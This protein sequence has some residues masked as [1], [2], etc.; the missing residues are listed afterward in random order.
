MTIF[1][2]SAF[3]SA[4]SGCPIGHNFVYRNEVETTM[5]VASDEARAGAPHGTL[6]L[7][8][9][10][11][12]GRGRQGRTFHSPDAENLYFTLVLRCPT[13]VH[14][15]LPMV[16]PLAVARACAGSGA[17][18]RIKWPNDIWIGTRK[19]CGMLIDAELGGEGA[20][21]LAGIGINVNGDPATVPGLETVATSLSRELGSR[22]NR[23]RLLARVCQEIE[24]GLTAS[25][26]EIA[27]G[28]A[29][30]SLVLGRQ[31]LLEF[32]DGSK[33]EGVAESIAPDG[34][35]TVRYGDG[36]L[37]TVHAAGVSLRPR[38]GG[39]GS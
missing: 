1:D 23:E 32:S 3:R 28:Y 2:I 27:E 5:T 8:E 22:Q 14:R 17:E 10:Q 11:T 31:V 13:E 39:G 37:A 12:A 36:T 25:A 38:A 29:A 24:R 19:V 9:A 30:F 16:L 7:A 33:G 6:V 35:L 21:A 34:A 18:A 4:L 15:R 20:V 26:D